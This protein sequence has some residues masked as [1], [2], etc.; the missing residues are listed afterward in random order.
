MNKNQPERKVNNTFPMKPTTK[1]LLQKLSLRKNVSM[2]TI[3]DEIIVEKAK[4]LGV[5]L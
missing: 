1:T 4:R 5:E 2:A 3:L